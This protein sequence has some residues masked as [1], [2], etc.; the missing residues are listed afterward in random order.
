[1]AKQTEPCVS[2]GEDTATGSP[3]YSDRLE[4]RT[5]A[6]PRFLCSLCARRLRGA[7]REVHSDEERERT[8]RGL[9]KGAFGFG[10]WAPGGH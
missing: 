9:E 4:D 2:C 6:E 3:L 1:M 8:Q 7:S 10:A 5:A